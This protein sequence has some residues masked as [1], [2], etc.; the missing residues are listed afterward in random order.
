MS[1]RFAFAVRLAATLVSLQDAA[2]ALSQTQFA[3]AT[4]Q[5]AEERFMSD[6]EFLRVGREFDLD[7]FINSLRAPTV[8]EVIAA[9]PPIPTLAQVI[10]MLGANQ[11]ARS[12]ALSSTAA[13]HIVELEH[14][15][16]DLTKHQALTTSDDTYSLALSKAIQLTEQISRIRQDAGQPRTWHEV[17]TVD[18]RITSLKHAQRLVGHDRRLWCA[19]Q[20]RLA[21]FEQ[22]YST[23]QLERAEQIVRSQLA[24]YSQLISDD[25]SDLAESANNLAAV[26]R[27]YGKPAD[28]ERLYRYALAMH[29]RLFSTDHPA[30]ATSLNNLA[31]TLAYRGSLTEA[32]L[33]A[34]DALEMFQRLTGNRSPAAATCANNLSV[35]VRA[36]G[37]L[38]EA[39]SLNRVALEIRRRTNPDGTEVAQAL[40]NLALVVADRGDLIE[41]ETLA[42]EAL[43]IYQRLFRGDAPDLA[44]TLNNLGTI[45]DSRGALVESESLKR[46]ALAMYMRLFPDDHA[47]VAAALNNLAGALKSRGA[48]AE[49]EPYYRDS[50]AMQRRLFPNDHPDIAAS[51]SNLAGALSA[52]GDFSRAEVYYREAL[53]IRRRLFPADHLDVAI[54]LGNLAANLRNTGELTEAERFGRDALAMLRRLFPDDHP[55]VAVAL[56]NLASILHARGSL[57]EAEQLSRC[58]LTLRQRLFP[59]DHPDKTISLDQLA[60]IL[61]TREALAEAEPLVREAFEMSERLRAGVVGGETQRAEFAHELRLGGRARDYCILLA[62]LGRRTEVLSVTERGRGRAALDLLMRSE[63]DLTADAH[64]Q[65]DEGRPVRLKSAGQIE[66]A[67]RVALSDAESLLAGRRKERTAW[68]NVTD[69]PDDERN[70]RIAS[71]DQEIATLVEDVKQKRQAC[72]R[73]SSEVLVELRGLFPIAQ[74]RSTEEILKVLAPTEAAVSFSW[75]AESVLVAVA[76]GGQTTAAIVA[77]SKDQTA[78]LTLTA[79]NLRAA[80]ASPSA[81]SSLD[82]A[83]V[84]KLLT[85]LLPESIQT[86]LTAAKRVLIVPDGPLS[87]VPFEALAALDSQSP[88]AG[89]AIVYAPSVTVY[90]D[91]MELGTGDQATSS[92]LTTMSPPAAVVL[93]AP[94]FD[95]DHQELVYPTQGVLLAKV[96][97][98]GNAA[99][100]GL[101]R[102]DVLLR[103]SDQKLDES[104]P[105][106]KAM[107]AVT[108]SVQKGERPADAPVKIAYWR[109]GKEIEAEV[110]LGKLGV[111][112][113]EGK[114][115]DGLRSMALID[116]VT[117]GGGEFEAGVSATDQVRLYGGVLPPLPGTQR[118]AKSIAALVGATGSKSMLLTGT[119]ASIPKLWDAVTAS[120]PKYLHLATHGLMG[121]ADRPMDASLALTQPE[122]PTPDDVGFLR[123]DDLIGR[124][125]GKLKGCELVVLSACDT[126]RGIQKGDSSFS[127]PLG[128]FFAGAKTVVASLWKVD[129]TAAQ[130]LMTRFYENLLGKFD[131]LRSVDGESY[132]AG[133]P[134]PKLAALREAQAWLRSL[135][136]EEARKRTEM[137]EEQFQLY[138]ASRGIG[139]PTTAPRR[140]LK[141]D[142]PFA[143]PYYWAAFIMIGDP[144]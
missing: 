113:Q 62:K 108:A 57:A 63:T 34:I 99:K 12:S 132:A 84:H 41:A 13:T 135:S 70:W 116:A 6:E 40:N 33:L 26:L 107:T 29:L 60:A 74:P 94:V 111:Q 10:Q 7:A 97:E 17:A 105:L 92:P 138:A 58:A 78:K 89:K 100:A 93:G 129:D 51:V 48:V 122:K 104:T 64:R 30:I 124:W 54:S 130:L 19:A 82:V 137:T 66:Q 2:T 119:D 117:R 133:K 49:A 143:H 23:G 126:Q 72:T 46:Q 83:T 25:D 4:S 56:H 28:A 106:Q 77:E 31:D 114:P 91:R 144:G 20:V 139:Q 67:A 8:Q 121:S 16:A 73:A 37:L 90:L 11:I 14:Q 65:D 101:R 128:F 110:P 5:T 53:S 9:R 86:Y 52:S 50:L 15:V 24:T 36:R 59:G 27:A 80:L 21:E 136:C 61:E 118:E 127:L 125:G 112:P 22:L 81:A 3:P 68:E 120:P 96:V 18:Q 45:L 38:P 141:Q 55:D 39:E 42:R 44:M 142:A 75:G 88:L 87:G 115:A 131:A 71:L 109:K 102:G 43:T 32:Q 35:I 95:R 140:E 103:Y 1:S 98:N 134:L 47:Y 85:T 123:L 76:G 69:K 79:T